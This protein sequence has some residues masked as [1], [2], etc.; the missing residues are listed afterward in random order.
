MFTLSDQI[1]VISCGTCNIF[2]SFFHLSFSKPTSPVDINNTVK[3]Y[4]LMAEGRRIPKSERCPL[5]FPLSLLASLKMLVA[6]Y[7]Y[8]NPSSI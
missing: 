7:D 2:Q 4:I 6:P 8:L 1:N 5:F 3:S